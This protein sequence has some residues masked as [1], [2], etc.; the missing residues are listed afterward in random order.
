[1]VRQASVLQSVLEELVDEL[2][3]LHKGKL[4]VVEQRYLPVPFEDVNPFPSYLIVETVE[5]S[6]LN[7]GLLPHDVQVPVLQVDIYSRGGSGIM[8]VTYF[9]KRACA[10]GEQKLVGVA[11]EY[12]IPHIPRIQPPDRKVTYIKTWYNK[13]G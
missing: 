12:G 11:A 10:L 13:P 5:R 2:A 4:S 7:T 3:P 9:N 1:M 8:A 6:L